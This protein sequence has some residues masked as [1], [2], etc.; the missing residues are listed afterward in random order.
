MGEVYLYSNITMIAKHRQA[1]RL[2]TSKDAI[3]DS[4]CLSAGLHPH[5]PNRLKRS[6]I[7]LVNKETLERVNLVYDR[8]YRIHGETALWSSPTFLPRIRSSP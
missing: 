7:Y 5:M 2:L 1:H 8:L 3:V 4:T 6:E